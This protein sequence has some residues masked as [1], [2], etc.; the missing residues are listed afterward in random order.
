MKHEPKVFTGY[1]FFNALFDEEQPAGRGEWAEDEIADA[2]NVPLVF[3]A[4]KGCKEACVDTILSGWWV[5][6]W[7]EHCI[8]TMRMSSDANYY[9]PFATDEEAYEVADQ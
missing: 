2:L 7:P 1:D 8:S 5:V 9:G 3:N 4:D 6:A